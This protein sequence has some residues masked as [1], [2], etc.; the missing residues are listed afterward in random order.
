MKAFDGYKTYA[1]ALVALG[2]AVFGVLYGAHDP[3]TAM[4]IILAAL[5]GAA[6]RDGIAKQ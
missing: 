5:G 2:Y 6:L 1:V 4:Q 3:N